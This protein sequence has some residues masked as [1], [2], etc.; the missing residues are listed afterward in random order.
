MDR[1]GRDGTNIWK[2][3]TDSRS[4]LN[5]CHVQADDGVRAGSTWTCRLDDMR[6][7]RR[8]RGFRGLTSEKE[9]ESPPADLAL[10]GIEALVGGFFVHSESDCDVCSFAKGGMLSGIVALAEMVDA[11]TRYENQ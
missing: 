3:V 7:T 10:N 4:R 2:P 8:A 1:D 9:P 5:G 6:R 11:V